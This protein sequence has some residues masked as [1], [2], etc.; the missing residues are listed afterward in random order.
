M[1]Q[2]VS[3]KDWGLRPLRDR[4]SA[5]R[6]TYAARVDELADKINRIALSNHAPESFHEARD[7]AARTARQLAKSLA[8]DG[9]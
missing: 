2:F 6:R 5:P 3:R 9:L 7:D 8:A 4:E 1:V